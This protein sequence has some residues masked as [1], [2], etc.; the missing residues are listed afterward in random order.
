MAGHPEPK[1]VAVPPVEPSN[2]EIT[3]DIPPNP[4][5]GDL[6]GVWNSFADTLK[7]ED[8][9]LFSIL[10][11]HT[12]TMENESKIIFQ[13]TN[14][15]QKEPLQKIQPSLLQH[16]RTA[17]DNENAEIEFVLAEKTETA[18]AYTA[19]DRF[20]QMS[21]KNPVLLTFKQQ[22]GLDFE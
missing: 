8:V 4:P 15:L 6:G 12:P 22:F 2:I 14:P 17:L 21:R 19:E 13:I 16:L 10:T 7:T 11:A 1:P 3:T 9:R 5:R 20:A 18:K